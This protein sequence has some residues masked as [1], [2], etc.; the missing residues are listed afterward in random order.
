[1]RLPTKTALATA[2]MLAIATPCL[3]FT[4]TQAP[5]GSDA[6]AS[7][8]SDPDEAIASSAS[9]VRDSVVENNLRAQGSAAFT[10]GAPMAYGVA[11]QGYG[12]SSAVATS[13]T[14][15]DGFGPT[16]AANTYSTPLPLVPGGR[17]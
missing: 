5:L 3:A 12:F 6:P 1:M 11:S 13:R 17:R 7:R 14:Y 9:S 2:L 15:A 16:G 10:G 4:V 8:F